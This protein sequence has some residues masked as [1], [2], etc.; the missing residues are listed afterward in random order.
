MKKYKILKSYPKH[1][2]N[3]GR[4]VTLKPG[5]S[6]YLKRES[7]VIRLVRMG[8]LK[9]IIEMPKKP[10]KINKR[11]KPFSTSDKEAEKEKTSRKS[12]SGYLNKKKNIGKSD[13]ES[14]LPK[15]Q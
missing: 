4:L 7:Q 10:K 12:K 3:S 5:K 9:P 6:T 14:D 11:P 13:G 15:T 1:I 2:T 8:F